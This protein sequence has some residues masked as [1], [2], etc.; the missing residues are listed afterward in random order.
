MRIT[1]NFSKI[2]LVVVIC[3]AI[4]PI[5]GF[6]GNI[7]DTTDYAYWRQL[8]SSSEMYGAMKSSAIKNAKP[9]GTPRDV[10]GANAL[11][12]ILDPT[13]KS[14]YI[15]HIQN[16]FETR[17][18]TMKIGT[19][20]A[21]SSVPSHEL[22][23]GLLALDVIRYDLEPE[24]LAG[25]EKILEEKIFKLVLKQWRPHGWA[26]R[27][28]WYKY[29]GDTAN[30]LEAKKQYDIDL[31]IHFLP[32]GISPS[33]SGYNMERFNVKERAAKNT[34]FDIMEY[35]GFHEYYSDSGMINMH[36]AIYGYENSPFGRC[37]FY[38]DSRGSQ[39]A[40]SVEDD[41]IV[42]PTTVR[43]A[44]FSNKA[45][46]YAMW[47]LREGTGL[48]QA[49]L[50]GYL[51][52]Y[53]VMAGPAAQN[54][55]IEFNIADAEMAPSR[56]FDNY[57]AL[58]GNKPSRDALYLSVQTLT[59][60]EEY[61]THYEA[62]AIGMAGYGEILLRNAGYDG[63]NADVSAGGLTTPFEFIHAHAESANTVLI[64][65]E[66]HSGK[67]A[68]GIVEGFTGEDVE[69]FRASNSTSIKGE[70]L[71]DVLFIQPSNNAN[72][73]YVVTDHVTTENKGDSVNVVWHPNTAKTQVIQDKTAYFSKIKREDGDVGPVLFGE[74][75]PVLK[76]FL[77]TP[78]HS[79]QKK[80]MVNQSRGNHYRAE[81]LYATY[82]TRDNKANVLTVLF[83]GDKN[84]KVGDMDRIVAGAY[85]GCKIKQGPVVDVALNSG[86]ITLE[87]YEQ[88]SFM[89]QD[90]F[91]RKLAGKLLS[92]FVKGTSFKSGEDMENGFKSD[93]PLA[94]YMNTAKDDKGSSGKIISSGASVTFYNSDVSSVKLN[95]NKLTNVASGENWVRVRIPKGTYTIELVN[96][97]N[98]N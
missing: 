42:S 76:T 13:N 2:V 81:Y 3:L 66:N 71:R 50:K 98:T 73:Y 68:D 55:P 46:K 24:V 49:T 47:T 96:N 31:R 88:E 48:R 26:M 9:D 29:A 41:V 57:A 32:D 21:T 44:R 60:K 97:S 91:Y 92:Y 82:P 40:W 18:K 94:L 54:N 11:A 69:Y 64:A 14:K 38:G 83:P 80:E 19:G 90:I 27:M 51:A 33:G 84:H 61:H 6:S 35:M 77:G 20:A 67:L 95:G 86:G 58:I 56:I 34:T 15:A 62:N 74:N 23:H 59:G 25:Y 4:N 78:P 93:A 70:H 79:V 65:G 43:A 45:Y 36:E 72:G 53:I 39:I 87:Q 16:K 52:S 17:I 63:P 10:F 89:G 37:I 8:A 75:T 12:Y 7:I 22:F 1:N 30:F 28:L 85:S 5:K